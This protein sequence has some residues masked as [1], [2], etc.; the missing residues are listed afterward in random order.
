MI[1][2]LINPPN[3]EEIQLYHQ[4]IINIEDNKL[5]A[6]DTMIL[7]I[8]DQGLYTR[9]QLLTYL[10][11]EHFNRAVFEWT[12]MEAFS[13]STYLQYQKHDINICLNIDSVL[14][15]HPS[16][17]QAIRE[18][19]H[20]FEYSKITFIVT[21]KDSL[22]NDLNYIRNIEEIKQFNISLIY[23][24]FGYNTTEDAIIK[25]YPFD[26]IK[27]HPIFLKN[28]K[29]SRYYR[30]ILKTLIKTIKCSGKIPI[31]EGVDCRETLEILHDLD[32]TQAKGDFISTPLNYT[33][34][35]QWTHFHHPP[36]STLPA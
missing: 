25:H 7:F 17:Y 10:S 22:L 36:W 19:K 21:D 30:S 3:L 28:I 32:C 2:V 1:N 26:Y 4:P 23:N 27:I 8:T 24:D 20:H 9:E 29:H 16:L 12:I 6:S 5:M 31:A 11:N 14:L 18:S 15:A 34:L 13:H 33:E 35:G